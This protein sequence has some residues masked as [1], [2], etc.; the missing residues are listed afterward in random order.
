WGSNGLGFSFLDPEYLGVSNMLIFL[1]FYIQFML[2]SIMEFCRFSRKF[3]FP[4][5]ST[6]AKGLRASEIEVFGSHVYMAAGFLFAS[7]FLPPLGLLAIFGLSCFGD[8]A[9]AQVGMRVGKHKLGFNRKKSWEGLIAGAITS[10]I[11]ASLFVGWIWSGVATAVFVAVD[12][13]T[14]NRLKASDNI[15]F[16]VFVTIAF[17]AFSLF[18]IPY[19]PLI[20]IPR[21]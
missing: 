10:Y 8:T 4:F 2:S 12:A 16:P 9:A 6:L 21:I 7:F 5:L 13:L 20:A 14:S 11:A 18:Q 15:A 19:A 3:D 1:V 17:L